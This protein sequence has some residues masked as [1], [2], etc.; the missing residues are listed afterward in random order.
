[1][2]LIG[3]AVVLALGVGV[4]VAQRAEAQQ[5]VTAYRIGLLPDRRRHRARVEWLSAH[6]GVWLRCDVRAVDHALGCRAGPAADRKTQLT[7]CC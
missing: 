5:A 2:R 4:T 7:P 1:M 3:L 6:G